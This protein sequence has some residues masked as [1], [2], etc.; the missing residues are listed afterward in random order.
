[1]RIWQPTSWAGL[2]AVILLAS[3]FA[4][5]Q[6][7]IVLPQ[8]MK[9]Y[10]TPYYIMMTDLGEDAAREAAIRMT[11]MAEEYYN[12]TRGFSGRIDRKL[13]FFLFS[14]MED[15]ILAGGVPGSAGV[16]MGDRINGFRLMAVTNV[17]TEASETWHTVQHEGFH[18]FAHAMIGPNLPIWVNEGLAEYFG[19]GI[20]TGDGFVTGVIPPWRLKRLKAGMEAQRFIPVRTMMLITHE[21][22]NQQL[23]LANYDQAWAMVHFLAHAEDGK[24]QQPFVQF[25]RGVSQGMDWRAAWMGTF[26]DPEGFEQKWR[27]YWLA[28]D[29]NPTEHLY[30]RATAERLASFL[31]RATMSGQT[32]ESWDAFAQAARSG[33][34]QMPPQDWLPPSLLREA[35]DRAGRSGEWSLETSGAQPAVVVVMPDQTRLTATWEIKRNR[36][37]RTRV[38][39]D[40]LRRAMAEARQMAANGNA[41]AARRH[42]QAAIKDNPKSAALNEAREMLRGLR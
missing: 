34:L 5:A 8:T 39:T 10:D 9:R 36:V 2:L 12:R 21:Q 14:R 4:A 25:M 40:T 20:F 15:Y 29:E 35:L 7:R 42:L 18:Q 26:G 33:Q 31:A 16:F 6:Q 27:A 24:Y 1:M 19:E 17:D 37:D 11:R 22:W 38:E 28:M 13:P 30:I 32:F 23:N 41:A 3:P